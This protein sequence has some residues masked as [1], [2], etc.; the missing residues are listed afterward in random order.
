MATRKSNF[1]RKNS[2]L[3][4]L[5]AKNHSADSSFDTESTASTST[6]STEVD[7]SFSRVEFCDA[8]FDADVEDPTQLRQRGAI[9]SDSARHG[10]WKD[11]CKGSRRHFDRQNSKEVKFMRRKIRSFWKVSS[12][13]F[14]GVILTIFLFARPVVRHS[15]E[16]R[17]WKTAFETEAKAVIKEIQRSRPGTTF[18]VLVKGGRIDLLK[19]TVDAYSR[20]SIV[21]EIQIDYTGGTNSFPQVLNRYGAGKVA[22]L[23][24]LTTSAVLLVNEGE[25]FSCGD[26][27]HSFEVWK[28]DPRRLLA[29]L[30]GGHNNWDSTRDMNASIRRHSSALLIHRRYTTLPASL[31]PPKECEEA[32]FPAQVA[33]IS[34]RAPL[35][36]KAEVRSVLSHQKKGPTTGPEQGIGPG[37]QCLNHL[38]RLDSLQRISWASIEPTSVLGSR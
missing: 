10:E 8:S 33:A 4:G 36:Y 27:Q 24:A 32:L 9:L 34:K 1:K 7:Q 26:L 6:N 2:D 19:R 12:F 28:K 23:G 29:F 38:D 35:L 16:F 5:M 18:T 25:T 3:V 13:F 37:G 30:G 22:K 17:R 11:P 14:G 31:K 15:F 21:N 20:C